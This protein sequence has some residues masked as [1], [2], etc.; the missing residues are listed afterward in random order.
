M[1]WQTFLKTEN[2]SKLFIVKTLTRLLTRLEMSTD[3]NNKVVKKKQNIFLL[4]FLFNPLDAAWEMYD[5]VNFQ[6]DVSLLSYSISRVLV[7]LL[8]GYD[9][10]SPLFLGSYT[11][12]GSLPSTQWPHKSPFALSYVC[13]Y[14]AHTL[15]V[16]LLLLPV[17]AFRRAG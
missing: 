5:G 8:L 1:L 4:V 11:G 13:N 12:G 6:A 15:H 2:R 7:E 17:L 16:L 14:M 3:N 9:S 10:N